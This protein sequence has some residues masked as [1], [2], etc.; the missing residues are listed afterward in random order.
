M[1][2]CFVC[3]EYIP[4]LRGGG[5]ASYIKEMAHGLS[6]KG[7]KVTVIC[8]SDDTKEEYSYQ[9]GKVEV[10]R[11][12][13]G[14][15]LI[16]EKES[17]SILKKF[18]TFYRF[19]SYR[20]RILETILKLKDI[21]IIEVPEYGAEGYYLNK[22]SIPVITR[23]HTPMLLDHFYFNIQKLNKNN[24]HYYWQ[25]LQEFKQ[26]KQAKYITSCSTSLKEWSS[27]LLGI[28]DN[29]IQ[30]IYNPIQTSRWVLKTNHLQNLSVKTILFAGTIC[31]WKGCGDLAE[32]CQMLQS[33]TQMPFE[34]HL[35]GKNGIYAEELQKKY[36]R[37]PWFK[38]IGK[39]PREELMK[40]YAEAD[41]ICFPSWWENMP[42]VCI[43]AMLCGGIVIGSNSGGMSEIISNEENGFLIPPHQPKI[44]AKTIQK[45]INLSEQRRQEISQ[46]AQ[47]RIRDD[48]SMDT[49]LQQ[50]ISYYQQV[51]NNSIKK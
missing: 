23:L 41:V 32:A 31:D 50:T 16:P 1:H 19:F 36:G 20:R 21:D 10:I 18:R 12:K 7:H 11:L 40:R 17:T 25:G 42:M 44:L 29:K 27:K 3:R 35:I 24:W 5:I 2:I 26:M 22:L 9:D 6:E 43:E 46:N 45:A 28:Q 14:D 48:F 15:F 49:I 38:L 13:G 33:N 34:L 39:I 37:Y 47:K 8:A 30:V 51:I 4:S